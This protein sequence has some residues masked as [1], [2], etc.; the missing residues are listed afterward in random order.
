MSKTLRL[1]LGDQ[2]NTQHPWFAD[3]QKDVTYVMMEIIPEQLYVKH[4]IQKII[5]F[6]LNMRHFA[7]SLKQ[8]GHHVIYF[9]LDSAEN[10]QDFKENLLWLK[11]KLSIKKFEYQLP[12]EVRLDEVL[13]EI[14][15]EFKESKV[16]DTYH[17][18]TSRNEVKDFFRGKKQ[19][20]M[21]NFYRYMRKKHQILVD[22][23][24][25]PIGGQWNFDAENRKKYDGKAPL[26]DA[27]LFKRDVTELVAL[28]DKLQIPYFGGINKKEYNYPV[29]R[30]EAFAL[31]DYF[32]QELLPAFGTYED[33]M[34]KEHVTLFHSRLSFILNLK[35]I[36]P[37]EVV[38]QVVKYWELHQNSITIAQVEGFTRQVIGWREYMRG[39]YWAE[40]PDFKE[41]NFFNYSTSLPT[42]FWDGK[43]K[44]NCLKHCI[45]NS[46]EHAYAH[47]IQR[48]MVIGNFTL[49]AGIHPSEVDNWFLG[50]YTDA[51][52]WVQITNTRGMSQ[53]ADGGIVGSKPYVSSANY[54]DKMSNYCKGCFYDKAKRHGNKACPFNSLYWNFYIAHE[55]KLRSNQRVSMMYKLLEKIEPDEKEKITEQA[56]KYLENLNSL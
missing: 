23:K 56:K 55:D 8:Q 1:I 43:V 39:I 49:L 32:C 11:Q 12:D 9:Y 24:Q 4:H 46:L 35:V 28:L 42:W 40:M 3:K 33:A 53:F 19:Y 50:V 41:K 44:M 45:S 10:Q 14:Q 27:L 31:L 30:Q 26:K 20:L 52:E 5:G 54:I 13:K 15:K 37:Y 18:L 51:V 22:D 21:E 6:F 7:L 36:S 47:H 25:N 17:F 16:Y 29:G 34:L 2:L 38:Q 48:L